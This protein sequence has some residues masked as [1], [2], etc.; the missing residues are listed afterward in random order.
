MSSLTGDG[1]SQAHSLTFVDEIGLEYGGDTQGIS[2]YVYNDFTVP[3]QT[4]ASQSQASQQPHPTPG[5]CM[6][7]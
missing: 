4:Q 3:S 1:Y 2:D 7:E 6:G 5:V